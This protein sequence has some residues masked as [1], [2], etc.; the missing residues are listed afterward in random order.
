[1]KALVFAAFVGMVL[2]AAAC[3]TPAPANPGGCNTAAHDPHPSA[4]VPGTIPAE[5]RQDCPNAVEQNSTDA[6][7][8]EHRFWGFDRIGDPG[9][10]PLRT[11][12]TCSPS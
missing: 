8:W 12:R 1:M 11:T 9:F 5:V 10:S 2:S 3:A 6:Q 7:M 4:H